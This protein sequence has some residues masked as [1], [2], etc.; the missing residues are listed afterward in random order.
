MAVLTTAQLARMRKSLR[1]RMGTN[2]RNFSKSEA[3]LVM[4]AFEDERVARR[5]TKHSDANTAASTS[6]TANRLDTMEEAY[7]EIMEADGI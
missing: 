2:V 1:Q 4:Q 7:M 5:T 3:N 6:F